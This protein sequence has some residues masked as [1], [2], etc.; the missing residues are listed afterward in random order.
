M[1]TASRPRLVVA[2]SLRAISGQLIDDQ[3]GRTLVSA[4]Q[5]ELKPTA[6]KKTDQAVAVGK[7]LAEKAQAKQITQAVFDR[8]GYRY[9][10]R[11]KA[12]A[13][14]TRKHGLKI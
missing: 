9:H 12:L 2:R 7:L 3:V 1:G 10:G 4:Y 14:S 8:A 6:G 5:R 13:E 11:I